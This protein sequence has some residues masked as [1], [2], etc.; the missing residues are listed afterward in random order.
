MAGFLFNNGTSACIHKVQHGNK[1]IKIDIRCKPYHYTCGKLKLI[2]VRVAK[3]WPGRNLHRIFYGIEINSEALTVEL[4]SCSFLAIL[5]P[6][7]T[8]NLEMHE[9]EYDPQIQKFGIKINLKNILLKNM[10]IKRKP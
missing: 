2:P 1:I 6:A 5:I 9:Q 3:Q 4:V 8:K 7:K 10:K